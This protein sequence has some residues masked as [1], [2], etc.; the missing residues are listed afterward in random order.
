MRR[1]ITILGLS[2]MVFG[3]FQVIARGSGCP[4]DAAYIPVYHA[5]IAVDD[6]GSW[7][8]LERIAQERGLTAEY[9]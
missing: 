9:P 1:W 6:F 2:F 7:E 4:E 3:L 5:C 8:A